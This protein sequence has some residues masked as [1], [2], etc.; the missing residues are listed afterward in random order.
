MLG[1]DDPQRPRLIIPGRPSLSPEEEKQEVEEMKLQV[2]NFEAIKE[3]AAG[4]PIPLEER[5]KMIR[6][7]DAAKKVMEKFLEPL[8]PYFPDESDTD[9]TSGAD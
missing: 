5:A 2:A 3:L 9:Q 8:L 6:S 7:A 1:K 4:L